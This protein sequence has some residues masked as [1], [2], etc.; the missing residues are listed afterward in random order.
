MDEETKKGWG[1]AEDRR[2]D[3]TSTDEKSMGNCLKLK[4]RK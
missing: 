2:A 4:G 3:S 1:G